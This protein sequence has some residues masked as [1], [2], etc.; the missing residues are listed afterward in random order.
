M[1]ENDKAGIPLEKLVQMVVQEKDQHCEDNNG[2]MRAFVG[3]EYAETALDNL[4]T[5]HFEK[6]P[7]AV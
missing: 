1:A 3:A 2:L 5:R 4:H 6:A 7:E